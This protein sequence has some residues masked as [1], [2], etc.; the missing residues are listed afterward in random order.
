M[1]ELVERFDSFLSILP[2]LHKKVFAGCPA[3]E[4]L[5]MTPSQ[6]NTL[7][8]LSQRPEWRMTDLSTRLHVSA[9]SLTTM[10]N[11]LI[12]TGL[13]E[14]TRSTADRRVVTVKLTENGTAILS[15]GKEQMRATLAAILATLPQDDREQL[16]NSL[17]TMNAIMSKIV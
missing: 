9:G 12:E 10:M 16:K 17:E 3:L 14:R 6:F 7:H 2:R 15:N 13:V 8:V 1:Y 11:R 4:E 5:H